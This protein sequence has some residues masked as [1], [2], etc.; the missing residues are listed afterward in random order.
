MKKPDYYEDFIL[1]YRDNRPKYEIYQMYV[2]EL[3]KYVKYLEDR[4][5]IEDPYKII[6]MIISVDI[7]TKK[8]VEIII[9]ALQ[10]GIYMG[11]DSETYRVASPKDIKINYCKER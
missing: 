5:A 10:K 4:I 7:K 9:K 6:K 11:L 3:E 2:A 8:D 1:K